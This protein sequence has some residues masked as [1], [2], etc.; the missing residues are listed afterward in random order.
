MDAPPVVDTSGL[1]YFTDGSLAYAGRHLHESAY[2][3][4]THSFIEVAVV[5]DGVGTHR[6]PAG[7]TRL[8]AGDAIL[9]RPGVWHEYEDCTD[10]VLYNCCFSPGLLQR[11]LA[12][13]RENPLLAHLL[14]IG[15]YATGQRGMMSV[16][17]DGTSA[18]EC[19][20]HLRALEEL[21]P[22]A[23]EAYQGDVVGRLTLF[24]SSL[25]RAAAGSV[26]SAT[27]PPHPAVGQAMRLLES[28]LADPWT[29]ADLAHELHMV[30]GSLVRLFKSAVGLPPMAYLAQQ[31][32]EV[33]AAMLIR[34][35]RAISQIAQAVGW[36]DPNYFARRFKAHFGL[37]ASTYRERFRDTPI[38]LPPAAP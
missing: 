4:H 14:W 18:A 3:A 16:R 2:P 8:A 6:S 26:R 5:V 30:P 25:A 12:W 19:V 22:C 32:A 31:R 20:D 15:P 37:S 7:R 35:D 28:R 17:L 33:A 1:V 24:L 13:A 9:L 34:D 27:P 36:P 38:T 11:E 29:L 21:R 23:A 10:L